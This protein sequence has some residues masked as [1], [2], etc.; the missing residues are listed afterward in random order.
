MSL[1]QFDTPPNVSP[2]RHSPWTPTVKLVLAI[3]LIV[4]VGIAIY[5]FRIVFIPLVIGGIM[6]YVF[7]PLARGIS[8]LTRIPHG[9]SSALIFLIVLAILI[10]V[11]IALVPLVV[12]QALFVQDEFIDFIATLE[13][14][15]PEERINILGLQLDPTVLA[16]DIGSALTQL[17]TG[18][19]AESV[20]LVMDAA[21]I[22]LLVIFTVIIGFYM[23]RD[24]D[25][26]LAWFKGLMPPVYRDDTALLLRQINE[27]WSAFFRGQII[28]VLVASALLSA[29]S[30]VIGLPRPLVMGLLGGLMEFLPSVG[31]AFW[32]ITALIVA[33]LEGSTWLPVSNVVF[34]LIVVALHTAYTQVDL[35]FL[36]PRIIGKQVHLHPMV[37]I[38]GIIIGLQV[39]GVLGVVLAAPTIA[40]LRVIG[41]YVY[42][43]FFDLEPFPELR[44]PVEPDTAAADSASTAGE[45]TGE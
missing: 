45:D 35:N 14:F 41:R 24:A 29:I 37:V 30:A 21:E 44:E 20:T 39:G 33:L 1:P 13:S 11:V 10:P 31:H 26:I 15:S 28:L 25:T 5:A 42:A 32:L 12:D 27:I 6:A 3:I 16:D 40:S 2:R 43:N 38:I 34:A 9:W 36:I 18:V 8:K 23:T 19:A 22:V 4:L 7:H 17:V